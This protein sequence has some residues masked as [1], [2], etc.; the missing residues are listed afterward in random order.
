MQDLYVASSYDSCKKHSNSYKSLRF[1]E[2]SKNSTKILYTLYPDL[3]VLL[4]FFFLL[5]LIYPLSVHFFLLN[6]LKVVCRYDASATTYS[7][8]FNKNNQMVLYSHAAVIEVKNLTDY[9]Y[10]RLSSDFISCSSNVLCKK[11][12]DY[13]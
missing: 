7:S 2:K 6:C 8:V 11:I 3:S 5:H 10:L 1:T 13:E 9:C 12:Q 4:F